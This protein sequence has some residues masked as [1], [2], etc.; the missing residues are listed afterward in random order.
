MFQA[1][2]VENIKTRIVCS[3]TFFKNLVVYEIM[4]K[5]IIMPERPQMKMWRMRISYYVPK[6]TNTLS[7]CVI[8]NAFPLQ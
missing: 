5:N 8:L 7:Q 4:W 1:E 6:A 2:A 3:V